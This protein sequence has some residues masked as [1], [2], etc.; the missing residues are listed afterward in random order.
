MD[1]ISI[2][3]SCIIIWN[4]WELKHMKTWWREIKIFVFNWPMSAEIICYVWC[5]KILQFHLLFT[6]KMYKYHLGGILGLKPSRTWSSVR[7]SLGIEFEIKEGWFHILDFLSRHTDL[8]FITCCIGSLIDPSILL[9]MKL[10]K[11][12]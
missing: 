12:K 9:R 10:M 8:C 11:G 1:S 3:R 7:W 4:S 2:S 5:L 6:D